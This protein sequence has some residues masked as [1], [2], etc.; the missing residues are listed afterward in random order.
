MK[1]VL[2]FISRAGLVLT[3]VPAFLFLTDAMTLDAVKK[4]MIL[5]AVLWLVTAPI[6]QSQNQ[7]PLDHPENR[8]NI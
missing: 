1:L 8:D 6:I 3:I 7:N 5:G 4:S 2:K